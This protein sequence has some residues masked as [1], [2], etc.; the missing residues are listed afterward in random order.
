MTSLENVNIW[1]DRTH[2][3][4]TF[5][6]WN[7]EKRAAMVVAVLPIHRFYVPNTNFFNQQSTSLALPHQ[8][9]P[10]EWLKFDGISSVHPDSSG[11]RLFHARLKCVRHPT[12]ATTRVNGNRSRLRCI[13]DRIDFRLAATAKLMSLQTVL[14]ILNQIA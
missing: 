5:M 1:R 4:Y 11:Q 6:F 3:R 14:I 2:G 13:E 9:C 8:R 10:H 7:L 12:C